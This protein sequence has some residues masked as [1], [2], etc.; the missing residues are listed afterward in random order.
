M[1]KNDKPTY[2]ELPERVHSL[3]KER[4]SVS[5]NDDI[6]LNNPL[7]SKSILNSIPELILILNLDGYVLDMNRDDLDFLERKKCD[8]IGNHY[9]ELAQFTEEEKQVYTD[10]FHQILS[11]REVDML[12]VPLVRT[13]IKNTTVE[14][15]LKLIRK[16]EAPFAVLMIVRNVSS[17]R[18]SD[19]ELMRTRREF[20]K[21]VRERTEQLKEVQDAYQRNEELRKKVQGELKEHEEKYSRVLEN[22]GSQYF[23][24]SHGVDGVFNY[25]SKSVEKILG[26]TTEEFMT[27]YTEFMTDNPAND[28]VLE[29]TEKALKGERQRPYEV[30][31]FHKKGTIKT[32]EVSEYPLKDEN[33]NVVAIEGVAKDI[34]DQMIAIHSLRQSEDRFR[35]IA[36]NSNDII[37]RLVPGKGIEYINPAIEKISGYARN[38]IIGSVGFLIDRVHPDDRPG[39]VTAVQAAAFSGDKS[40]SSQ[41]HVFRFYAK[42]GDIIWCE[43]Q[44]S[45]VY[46]ERG[47]IASIEFVGRNITKRVKKEE[48]IKHE[49]R[50]LDSIVDFN[51]FA[52]QLLDGNGK[53]VRVN[54]AFIELLGIDEDDSLEALDIS[55][56]ID[57][58][59]TEVLTDVKGGK[60]IQVEDRA[61]RRLSGDANDEVYVNSVIFPIFGQE[62]A[63]DNIVFMHE[64]VTP[65][66]K[67]EKEKEDLQAQL[68]QSQKM[69]AIGA[70]AGGMAHE[71]NN[72]LS[73]IM[74]TAEMIQKK[75]IPEDSNFKRV[76]RIIKSSE[77]AKSLS[78]KLLTFARKEKLHLRPYN[79]NDAVKETVE[80][81]DKSVPPH[82]TV[83]LD[84]HD[85]MPPVWGD[86]NQLQQA[87]LNLCINAIDSI[88]TSGAIIIE[89]YLTEDDATQ[90]HEAED[91]NK[92]YCVVCVKDTGEGIPEHISNKIFEPFFT[93]KDKGRGTGLGLSITHSIVQDHEGFIKLE[94]EVGKGT[95]VYLYLPETD[96]EYVEGEQSIKTDNTGSGETILVIDDKED[97]R[98]VLS[99]ILKD[100]GYNTIMAEGGNEAINIYKEKGAEIDLAL[101]DIIM[102]DMNGSETYEKLKELN[103]NVKIIIVSA[104]SEDDVSRELREKGAKWFLQKPYKAEDLL[105]MVK[106][107]IFMKSS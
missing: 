89:T 76:D 97:V 51:P 5:S 44:P 55:M 100:A 25:L 11:G 64:D 65:R 26:Y 107:V 15:F 9:T 10:L 106:R 18:N 85:E 57:R 61:I 33:G 87:L 1:K 98:Q 46:D 12:E 74:G 29:Y 105:A 22:I 59:A 78:T 3:E 52:I 35:R 94:S 7:V 73:V 79:I 14:V 21:I 48:E 63:V 68:L 23:I 104:Y 58:N 40:Q 54:R 86:P 30:E 24:Y 17:K 70:L 60:V 38:E 62:G 4:S 82:I 8:V 13:E 81:L 102:P 90:K 49:K 80:M 77:R 71:F 45:M 34:T 31:L 2:D 37:V 19:A 75:I 93:T 41:P 32:L 28:K 84:L 43:M 96:K 69:E 16:D 99:D 20:E 6:S 88:K 92:R 67:A 103:P 42:S 95:S 27:H 83:T 101:L 39:F 36:E 91:A 47:M 56:F 66:K 50:I 53:T 72:I